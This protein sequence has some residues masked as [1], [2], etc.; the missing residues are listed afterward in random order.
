M[1]V[2]YSDGKITSVFNPDELDEEEKKS[3]RERS[4]KAKTQL[5][6]DSE[7]SSEDETTGR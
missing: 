3:L 2:K 4:K 6:D 1:F 7:S 5:N